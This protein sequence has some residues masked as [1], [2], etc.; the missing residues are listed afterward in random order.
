MKL[1]K[2]CETDFNIVLGHCVGHDSFFFNYSEASVTVLAAKDRVLG[3]NL[4]AVI[5]TADNYYRRL[6]QY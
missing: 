6:Y 5:Y 3:H 2:E 4:L 1:L